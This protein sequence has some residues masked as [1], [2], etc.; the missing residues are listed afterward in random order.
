MGVS[1]SVVVFV[2]MFH[3]RTRTVLLV[4]ECGVERGFHRLGQGGRSPNMRDRITLI[5]KST[6]VLSEVKFS[7][8]S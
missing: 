3:F 1:G 7:K 8:S 6:P 5:T 4:D 2:L